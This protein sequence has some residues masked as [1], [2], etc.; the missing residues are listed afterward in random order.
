MNVSWNRRLLVPLHALAV[1]TRAKSFR[2]NP[3]I[4]SPLLNR[5]GL[6]VLRRRIARRAGVLRRRQLQGLIA[7]A[8]RLAFER[9]GFILKDN[10]LDPQTFARLRTEILGFSAEAR[11]AVVGD[12]L[13]RLIPLDA[14]TLQSLPTA[15]SVIEGSAY[16]GLLAYVGSFRRRPHVYV[17]TVFSRVRDAEPDEQSFFH[18]DTFHPTVKSWLYLEDVRE[19]AL[20][21]VY[22]PGSHQV[23][24]R[25]LAWERRV[26]ISAH[27]G[28]DRLSAEG[29]MRISEP[30]IRRLGYGP[31]R[32]LPAAAN[33]LI[34]ADTSG[35]HARAPTSLRT[36]RV[37][38]W[39]YTRSNPFLPWTFGDLAA[40]P[41]LRGRALRLY[42]ALTDPLKAFRPLARDWRWVG[43]RSPLSPLPALHQQ[44]QFGPQEQP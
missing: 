11:E 6:H 39:A 27:R 19:D 44:D 16:R 13:T 17:Q 20:P 15:R 5:W 2:D 40:L 32:R 35:F 28:T 14:R 23:N 31:P 4:G 24:R 1:A 26:S 41:G 42:W 9:D 38:I 37:S 8:D 7:P 25:R 12:T 22:V 34:V 33:T 36:H 21:F 30:E 18:S 29:S 10:F 3:V 43:M